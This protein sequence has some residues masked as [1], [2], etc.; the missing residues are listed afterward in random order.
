MNLF[1][2]KVKIKIAGISAMTASLAI[3]SCTLDEIPKSTTHLS[4][5]QAVEHI[6]RTQTETTF[7]LACDSEWF[8]DST[9]LLNNYPTK[10]LEI[11]PS[12]GTGN[13]AITVRTTMNEDNF[14]RSAHLRFKTTNVYPSTTVYTVEQDG[15]IAV[16]TN[17]VPLNVAA[18]SAT[19]AGSVDYDPIEGIGEVGFAIKKKEDS[20]E[21]T[22]YPQKDV[23]TAFE[24]TAT[25]IE[26]DTPYEFKAYAKSYSDELF[27]GETG[28][29]RVALTFQEAS[30]TEMLK[31][32]ID[33]TGSYL[34]LPYLLGD[35]TTPY[36]ISATMTPE[37]PGLEIGTLTDIVLSSEGGEIMVPLTGIPT[38][39]GEVTFTFT[40]LPVNP[41][42]PDKQYTVTT[43][44]IEGGT[45]VTIYYESYG[46]PPAGVNPGGNASI[47]ADKPITKELNLLRFGQP[48]A[49]YIRSGAGQFRS[50]ET[51][52]VSIVIDGDYDNPSRGMVMFV[53]QGSTG[54][55]TISKLT[56]THAENI[57]LSFA[58][59]KQGNGKT[60]EKE[61]VVVEYST[62][63]GETWTAVPYTRADNDIAGSDKSMN[64]WRLCTTAAGSIP[65]VPNLSIRFTAQNIAGNNG[66]KRMDDV[67]LIGDVL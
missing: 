15:A 33:A 49:E 29:F 6:L 23:A 66:G 51:S 57:R 62:D 42:D 22:L 36:T 8:L 48:N 38:E 19:L 13:T 64:T 43:T 34:K 37:I 35:G 12:S 7:E 18:G 59:H 27:Y 54:S 9:I 32:N 41:D 63:G 2:R 25:G 5:P 28:T 16:T 24:Y 30:L 3:G 47:V 40:G 39:Y 4:A 20:G 26:F 58:A 56:T 65:S 31:S 53:G 67:K 52:G 46:E 44:I 17:T 60:F 14:I 11:E 45:D 61:D 10:W 50:L 1:T 21:F 55:W